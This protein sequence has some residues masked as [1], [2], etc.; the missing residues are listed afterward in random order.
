MGVTHA[1]DGCH[2]RKTGPVEDRQREWLLRSTMETSIATGG[3]SLSGIPAGQDS[4]LDSGPPPTVLMVN[5]R[6][7]G[8]R[9]PTQLWG[10]EHS[11][12]RCKRRQLRTKI[13]EV[14]TQQLKGTGQDFYRDL[15]S[16]SNPGSKWWGMCTYTRESPIRGT[17]LAHIRHFLLV[18][19]W[20][21]ASVPFRWALAH[22]F[23][24]ILSQYIYT[25]ERDNW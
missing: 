14:E 23:S 13:K 21:L 15:A 10:L 18:R 3:W 2:T 22:V 5:P 17:T 11:P 25:I 19:S 7:A 8:T 6:E 4:G 9:P 12:I 16:T 20:S 1:T 24:V